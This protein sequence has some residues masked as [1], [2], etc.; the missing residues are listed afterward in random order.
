MLEARGEQ[1]WD[2]GARNGSFVVGRQAA[3]GRPT[4]V[5]ILP[6]SSPIFWFKLLTFEYN[7]SFLDLNLNYQD[8]SSSTV[9]P[10]YKVR[11]FVQSKLT[12]YA[13]WPHERVIAYYGSF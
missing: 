4:K 12:M 3:D 8:S 11:G 5:S 6:N 7:L 9:T 13:G 1:R 2:E 10:A